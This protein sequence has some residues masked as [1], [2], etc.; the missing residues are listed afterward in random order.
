MQPKISSL[1]QTTLQIPIKQYIYKISLNKRNLWWYNISECMSIAL[2]GQIQ[3]L[4]LRVPLV[5]SILQ[6]QTD[7]TV[8]SCAVLPMGDDLPRW[9]TVSDWGRK[10]AKRKEE[11][12]NTE[13]YE[14]REGGRRI[15]I[16]QSE[17]RHTKFK[18]TLEVLPLTEKALLNQ[19]GHL[20]S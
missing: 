19:Q 7:R 20:G 16:Q 11:L 6:W 8:V 9:C 13:V 1:T 12:G 14:G 10:G 4:T 3:T 5:P 18:M 17:V 15:R 2:F